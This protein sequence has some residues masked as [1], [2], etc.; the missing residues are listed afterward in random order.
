SFQPFRLAEDG[1]DASPTADWIPPPEE[2]LRIPGVT[3]AARV[4]RYRAEIALGSRWEPVRFLGIDRLDFA[5]VA[6]FRDDLAD[7]SLGMLM[8]RLATYRQGILVQESFLR[9]HG[10]RPRDTLSMRVALSYDVTALS[11]FVIA[12]SFHY[13]PTVYHDEPTVVGSLEYLYSYFGATFPHNIWLR[14]APGT[15]GADIFPRLPMVNLDSINRRDTRAM[16]AEE[17]NKLERVGV[18]G[19]LSVGFLATAAMGA[20]GLLVYSY[21]SLRERLYQFALLR[22]LGSY[23]SQIVGQVLLEYAVLTAYGAAAAVIV[24][25][26]ASRLFVPFFRVTEAGAVA[27]P[28]LLALLPADE[29]AFLTVL[30]AGTMILTELVVVGVALYR[31]LFSMLRMGVQR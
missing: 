3:G 22:A 17:Q 21:A 20:I 26:W 25:S 16:I 28:P 15:R 6:W 9:E 11:T 1:G 14:L 2:F 24:G 13:F 30:F 31:Q 18:F 27:L 10:L 8:N 5:E 7:G 19:T 4:G 29:I 12:G 23:R